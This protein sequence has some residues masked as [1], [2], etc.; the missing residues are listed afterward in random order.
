MITSHSSSVTSVWYRLVLR[1]CCLRVVGVHMAAPGLVSATPG[2]TFDS[3]HSTP[4]ETASE[5]PTHPPAEALNHA[6]PQSRIAGGRAHGGERRGADREL[7]LAGG[8]SGTPD[9]TEN[10]RRLLA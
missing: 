9:G 5:R 6:G 4:F 7:D 3:S 10:S 2:I 1:I 8:V